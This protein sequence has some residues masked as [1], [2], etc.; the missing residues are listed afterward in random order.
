MRLLICRKGKMEKYLNTAI[1]E[2][3]AKFPEVGKILEDYNIGCVP[4]A[5]GSCLLRDIVA[6]HNL[7]KEQ[8][9]ELMYGIEKAIY[10]QRDIKKPLFKQAATQET[11]KE[12]KYS[13][14]MQRL[15]D[16]H[17]L[18]KKWIGLIPEVIENV[19]IGSAAGRQLIL[20]GL[21]FIRFFADKFHHA[22]EEEILFEYTDKNLDIIK[23]MLSD[24]EAARAHVRAVLEAIERRDKNAI[25][26]HLGAYSELL[27]EHI[28]KEDEILY[29]WIDRGLAITQVG[30]LFAKFNEAEERLDKEVIEKCKKFI[31]E[32]K[33]RIRK[34]KIKQNTSDKNRALN[35][36]KSKI[37][38]N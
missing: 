18:I 32:V 16:E 11:S 26:E 21:D 6:I 17:I 9:L 36:R 20:D 14:P 8:E 22:K 3:I 24:H 5:L 34:L 23:T 1:K 27:T 25:I 33:Q 2:L 35:N 15:V 4:C 28:K 38:R 31:R 30:E 13:P 12:I 19:D 10:P 37:D 7:S 29:P